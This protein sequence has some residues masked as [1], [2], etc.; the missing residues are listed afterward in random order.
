MID[1][2][3]LLFLV[4]LYLLIGVCIFSFIVALISYSASINDVRVV[5]RE[6]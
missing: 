5:K 1:L 4:S 3:A 6:E 2:I